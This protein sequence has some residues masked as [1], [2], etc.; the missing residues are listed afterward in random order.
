VKRFIVTSLENWCVRLHFITHHRPWL[1][2][3][4]PNGH[5]LLATWS[6]ALAERW[7]IPA[8]PP[9]QEGERSQ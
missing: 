6:F 1:W 2:L 4:I 9:V 3:P 5:C 7:S 8:K